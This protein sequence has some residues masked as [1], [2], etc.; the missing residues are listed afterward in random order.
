MT[1]RLSP[2]LTFDGDAVDA[3]I[4]ITANTVKRLHQTKVIAPREIGP[5]EITI[6]VPE[7]VESRAQSD[8]QGWP[9]GQTLLISAG[10]QPGILQK[11]G[12]FMNLR[13]PGTTPSGTELL[14]FL[15]I[16]SRE[17]ASKSRGTRPRS[18]SG[19]GP[20]VTPRPP[21]AGRTSPSSLRHSSGNASACIKGRSYRSFL[22]SEG[23]RQTMQSSSTD[24]S[25]VPGRTRSCLPTIGGPY[26]AL[27]ALFSMNL[28]NYVD[29]YTFFGV[30][31]II[32]GLH[33]D[34]V[35]YGILSVAFMV[36]YTIVSPMIGWMGDRYSRRVLLA[37][38]VGIWSLATV[39]TA[40]SRHFYDMFF[41]RALLGVGEATYGVIAPRCLPTSS[42]RSTAAE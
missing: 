28:L 11:K 27:A 20:G 10:I 5:A 42:R 9:L 4:D 23:A 12:G 19:P 18:R 40:F 32:E 29:R 2:L 17:P 39:G 41:W 22:A 33:I 38:G 16:E 13:L 31:T 21:R 35:E 8:G 25:V 36:V 24:P 37:T 14:V 15:D 26:F 34:E 1:L 30:G 6:D 3:A 7:V